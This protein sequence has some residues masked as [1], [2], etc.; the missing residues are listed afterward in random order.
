MV[1]L[2][3]KFFLE[4]WKYLQNEPQNKA[5]LTSLTLIAAGGGA[6]AAGECWKTL[7]SSGPPEGVKRG[8]SLKVVLD[9]RADLFEFSQNGSIVSLTEA[10]QMMDPADGLPENILTADGGLVDDI[11]IA[12][13]GSKPV[14]VG[15]IVAEGESGSS[16]PWD[17]SRLGNK[18]AASRSSTYVLSGK[19]KGKNKGGYFQDLIW[20]PRIGLEKER[21]RQKDHEL[22]RSLFNAVDVHGGKSVTLSQLG[23]DYKVSL[24]KKDNLFRNI[25]LLD[26]LK[27]YEDVFSLTPDSV[28]GGWQVK[29][30]PGAEAALPDADEF[31]SSAQDPNM[32]LPD[33]I[34]NPR[35]TFD[36]IQSLRIELLHALARRGQKVPLQELGQEPRVQQRKQAIHQ[37]RK[38]VD[39]IKMFPS[40]FRVSSEDIG[41]P[42][43]QAQ[44]VIETISA[45]VRDTSMI[46]RQAKNIDGE[47]GK[48]SGRSGGNRGHDRNDRNDRNDRGRGG[49]DNRGRSRSR[50]RGR[51]RD[52]GPP[53]HYPPPHGA[54]PPG[55][56]PG[57]PPP[58]GYPPTS[59]YGYS[60]Y[61]QPPPAHY[62]P[63]QY[64]YHHYPQGPPP[65]NYPPPPPGYGYP[66]PP[67]SGYPPP[68]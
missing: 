41:A 64:D 17:A 7:Q 54:P 57:Y 30:V 44:M 42:S 19:G 49:R 25:R 33:R 21:E 61:G 11:I 9:E 2:K 15:A 18:Q 32:A 8:T 4:V 10:A 39:F 37:G 56:H 31:D 5:P 26:V 36:K 62:P 6:K 16:D 63:P 28:S 53:Q 58:A 13:S 52:E 3:E 66:P 45:N 40:N 60:A 59:P 24:L 38:L 1:K 50:S 12:D 51:G 47:R 14:P 68:H 55:H 67:H 27:Y 29:L 48:G 65:A 22:V 46:D 34:E 35:S 20:T 43:A 23:S